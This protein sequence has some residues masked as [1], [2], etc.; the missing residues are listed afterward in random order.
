MVDMRD[1]PKDQTYLSNV[2]KVARATREQSRT[3]REESRRTVAQSKAAAE[4]RKKQRR[5]IA[6][7]TQR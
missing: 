3:L 6:Y 2:R 7:G 1:E 5:G 4:A